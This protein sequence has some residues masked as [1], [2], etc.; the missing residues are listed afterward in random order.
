V[1]ITAVSLALLSP[2]CLFHVAFV[3]LSFGGLFSVSP[4]AACDFGAIQVPASGS[5]RCFASQVRVKRDRSHPCCGMQIVATDSRSTEQKPTDRSGNP[6]GKDATAA[7]NRSVR[8]RSMQKFP[9]QRS[10]ASFRGKSPTKQGY[11]KY[12]DAF[13]EAVEAQRT[14]AGLRNRHQFPDIAR[15][16]IIP[17]H[18]RL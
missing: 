13:S 12:T 15:W 1:I 4:N 9:S 10:R 11:K 6:E 16:F 3:V 2:C 8:S 17:P 14:L 7:L 18:V 5:G